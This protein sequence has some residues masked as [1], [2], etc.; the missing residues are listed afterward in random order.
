[1]NQEQNDEGGNSISISPDEMYAAIDYDSNTLQVEQDGEVITYL[2]LHYGSGFTLQRIE[3]FVTNIASSD[4]LAYKVTRN[5]L[6]KA[7]ASA[8]LLA[9]YFGLCNSMLSEYRSIYDYSP[10]VRVFFD[11]CLEQGLWFAPFG[12]YPLSPSPTPG[13]IEAERFN[14]LV[15]SIREQARSKKTKD[16]VY[17]RAYNAVRNYRD[18]EE[19]IDGLFKRHSRLLVIRLDLGYRK[20]HAEQATISDAQGHLRRFFNNMRAN[21]LF[22]ALLGQIWKMECGVEKGVHFHLILFFDGSKVHKDAHL[23]S[24]IGTYWNEHIT[25]GK[26]VFYNCNQSKNTYKRCGIGMVSH[27]DDNKRQNL[28]LALQYLTK[29]DQYLRYKPGAKCRAFGKGNMPQQRQTKVGRPRRQAP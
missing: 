6:G 10:Y 11:A 18:A 7:K 4:E 14:K 24:R 28:L 25:E 5:E 13:E 22:E 1:M 26:G 19:Y 15:L 27:D 12:K 21:K 29:E 16:Q 23:G 2:G 8:L 9:K 20:E 17:A 3:E